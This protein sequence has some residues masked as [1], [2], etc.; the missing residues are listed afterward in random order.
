MSSQHAAFEF[1]GLLLGLTIGAVFFSINGAL[2]GVGIGA[3]VGIVVGMLTG[4]TIGLIDGDLPNTNEWDV[5]WTLYPTVSTIFARMLAGA[6]TIAILFIFVTIVDRVAAG[7][8]L[9]AI[10]GGVLSAVIGTLLLIFVQQLLGGDPTSDKPAFQLLVE[11]VF[12]RGGGRLGSAIAGAI[13][14]ASFGLTFGIIVGAIAGVTAE[15]I[16]TTAGIAMGIATTG[17]LIGIAR[18]L[19][20]RLLSLST[21]TQ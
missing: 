3:V 8:V 11:D 7:Q 13:L 10:G 9:W 5:L 18:T 19:V 21:T 16:S 20:P 1:A 15:R 6:L 2:I 14:V 4:A 12:A 17:I